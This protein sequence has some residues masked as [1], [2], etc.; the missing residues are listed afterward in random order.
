M[1]ASKSDGNYMLKLQY[2][3]EDQLE[4]DAVIQRV[5]VFASLRTPYHSVKIQLLC[6]ARVWAANQVYGRDD[7]SLLI[8]KMTEDQHPE[9]P[10]F[11][12]LTCIH[13]D[14][15]L[16]FKGQGTKNNDPY[17]M[18]P[19]TI[20]CIVNSTFTLMNTPVNKWI[21]EKTPVTPMEAV[22]ILIANFL[23]PDPTL[24]VLIDKSNQ[25]EEKLP[26]LIIPPMSFVD[27]LRFLDQ[28]FGL[29]SGPAFYFAMFPLS[30]T[31]PKPMEKKTLYIH[32]LSTQIKKSEMW[33]LYVLGMDGNASK[34]IS[35]ELKRDDRFYTFDTIQHIFTGNEDVLLQG[36]KN[37]VI[38]KPTNKLYKY[39]EMS[40]DDLK[41]SGLW[42]GPPSFEEAALT[43]KRTVFRNK[44]VSGTNDGNA[45]ITSQLSR[46]MS[47]SSEI[48][49]TI[50]RNIT[51]KHLLKIGVP[52]EIDP[53]VEEYQMYR[54][55]YIVSG[56]R[57]IFD[58]TSGG[59]TKHGDYWTITAEMRAIRSNLSYIGEK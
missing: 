15:P 19:V 58:K 37:V 39:T 30:K 23:Q 51:L 2:Q 31:D 12:S 22:D 48:Q 32:D 8:I 42:D 1:I 9:A 25:N 5:E 27:A 17:S 33:K 7:Y 34:E 44:N 28:S 13:T 29:F 24:R 40:I 4:L 14:L 56:S 47:G 54:G 21:S 35:E 10:V 6:N 3:N 38:S 50:F 26:Q 57:I 43:S 59:G 18:D 41:M 16:T 20:Y 46:R 53:Q 11:L 45:F 55:K 49:F 36:G 52:V